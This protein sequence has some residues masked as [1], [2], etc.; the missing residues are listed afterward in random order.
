[1]QVA[2]VLKRFG[3]SILSWTHVGDERPG[4]FP[5]TIGTPLLASPS[6]DPVLILHT[7]SGSHDT[8]PEAAVDAGIVSHRPVDFYG[9]EHLDESR[10]LHGTTDPVSIDRAAVRLERFMTA[11]GLEHAWSFTSAGGRP[12]LYSMTAPPTRVC[13]SGPALLLVHRSWSRWATYYSPSYLKAFSIA[14]SVVISHSIQ[15]ESA[16]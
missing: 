1:M 7:F 6:I 2:A 3:L 14:P 12:I 11:L 13:P 10:Q 4:F 15:S 5:P 8:P 16:H 9:S